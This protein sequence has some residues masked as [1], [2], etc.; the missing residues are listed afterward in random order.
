MRARTRTI[1]RAFDRFPAQGIWRWQREMNLWAPWGTLERSQE[2]ERDLM[3]LMIAGELN[4]EIQRV[5]RL[6]LEVLL[7]LLGNKH[8]ISV[9]GKHGQGGLCVSSAKYASAMRVTFPI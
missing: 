6:E 9:C 4:A 2:S 3:I 7:C 1:S 5:T 8:A